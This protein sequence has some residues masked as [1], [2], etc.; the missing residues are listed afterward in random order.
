MSS[1]FLY[2]RAIDFASPLL[3]VV[4]VW[5]KNLLSSAY[6]LY[7]THIVSWMIICASVSL[8]W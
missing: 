4:Q 8:K 7:K 2:L 1:F 6:T 5:L 3:K